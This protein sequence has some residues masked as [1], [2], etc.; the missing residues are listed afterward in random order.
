M[1]EV[2]AGVQLNFSDDP[3]LYSLLSRYKNMRGITWKRFFLIGVADALVKE[4]ENP[5]LVVRVVEYLEGKR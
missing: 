2:S 3:E 5:D 1:T 4:N